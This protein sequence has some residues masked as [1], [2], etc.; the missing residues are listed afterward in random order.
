MRLHVSTFMSVSVLQAKH[1]TCFLSSLTSIKP[2]AL[3]QSPSLHTEHEL[4]M[5]W[6]GQMRQVNSWGTVWS[7][8][9]GTFCASHLGRASSVWHTA[10]L[11]SLLLW[12]VTDLPK[13]QNVVV[14]FPEAFAEYEEEGFLF[15]R[16]TK[17]LELKYTIRRRDGRAQKGWR[18]NCR[19]RTP[20]EVWRGLRGR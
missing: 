3:P 12:E 14:S 17:Q 7:Q 1:Q 2:L 9:T 18:N 11:T 8:W 6:S 5:S 20:W 15:R 4:P 13:Q 16:Q 10:S 19:R